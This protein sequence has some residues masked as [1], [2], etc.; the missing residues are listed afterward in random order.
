VLALVGI[1]GLVSYNVSRRTHEIGI[2][3]AIGASRADV[4]RLVLGKGLVVVAV[5]LS[6][7]LALGFAMEQLMNTTLWHVGRIDFTVYLAVVPSMLA[8]TTLAAYLPALRASRIEPT[9]ALRYE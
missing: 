3:M 7:G 9:Q 4:L 5:G 1:Y 2:R 6:I 8:V